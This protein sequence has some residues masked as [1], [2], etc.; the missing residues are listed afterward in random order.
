[1][2]EDREKVADMREQ[3]RQG[4]YRVE[5]KAVADAILRRLRD[6][7]AARRE[8]VAALER[9]WAQEHSAQTRCSYPDNPPEASVKTTPGGPSTTRPTGVTSTVLDRLAS[10]VSSALRPDAGTQA[11]SS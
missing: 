8:Q 9:A 1:M 11:Q 2:D 6:L 10:A 4:E 7:A 5:P 3:I